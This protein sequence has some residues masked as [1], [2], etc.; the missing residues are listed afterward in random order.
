M[1]VILVKFLFDLVKK[2]KKIQKKKWRV[3]GTFF[4]TQIEIF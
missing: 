4:K 1:L 3:K 2:I